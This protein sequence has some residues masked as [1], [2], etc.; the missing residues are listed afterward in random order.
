MLFVG[1]GIKD[2]LDATFDNMYDKL[3]IRE[4]AGGLIMR[5]V[6]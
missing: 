2:S 6:M 5:K 4:K 3:G 1:N